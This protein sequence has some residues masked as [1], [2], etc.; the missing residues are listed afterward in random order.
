MRYTSV[1]EYEKSLSGG[2]PSWEKSNNTSLAAALNWYNYYSDYKESKKFAIQYLKH[3]KEDKNV[4][5]QIEKI[6]EDKFENLGFVCRMEMR[7]ATLSDKQKKWIKTFFCK[8]EY[9]KQKEEKPKEKE[10]VTNTVSV[11]ER[12]IEKSKE[13]IAELEANLDKCIEEK[14]FKLF[15]PYELLLQLGVKGAHTA[16]IKKFYNKRLFEFENVQVTTDAVLKEGYSNF[17]KKQLKEYIELLNLLISDCDKISHNA[18][19]KRTPRK[20]KAKSV[21]K[22]LEKVQYKKDDTELKL[23]SINPSEILGC[24]QLWVYNTKLRKL[25]VYNA[26]DADGLSVKGTTLLNFT[27]DSSVQKTIRK[28]DVVLSAILKASKTSIKKTFD[29]V[30]SVGSQLTGRLNADTILLKAF[31]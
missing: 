25:G 2:E 7:G 19:L 3:I 11:Q 12:V 31:K 20:K 4:I 15:K 21:E 30:N 27:E 10:I 17:T 26:K 24:K 18:K 22:V 5:A 29:A 28:P 16:N 23:V 9:I 1:K 14:N 13:H 8:L 6:P